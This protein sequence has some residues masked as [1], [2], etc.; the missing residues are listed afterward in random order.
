MASCA[1]LAGSVVLSRCIGASSRQEFE[2][3][4]QER[5]GGASS[6]ALDAVL[7]DMRIR[8]G[9]D[10]PEI[11]FGRVDFASTTAVF[12]VRNP[13]RPHELDTYFYSNEEFVS[14][15]PIRLSDSDDLDLATEPLSAFNFNVESLTDRAIVEFESTGGYAKSVTWIVYVPPAQIQVEVE[16]PRSSGTAVFDARGQLTEFRR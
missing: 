12:E 6:S 9:V 7:D 10:D 16:S 5:G 1:A 8:T 13:A 2:A 4:V 3:M 15:K 14:A 11:R